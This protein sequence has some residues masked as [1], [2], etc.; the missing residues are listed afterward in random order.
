M[1]ELTS[2]ESS[3][4]TRTA[5]MSATSSSVL[6]ETQSHG[7]ETEFEDQGAYLCPTGLKKRR[8]VGG[9]GIKTIPA[10]NAD[11][12]RVFSLE[13]RIKTEFHSSLATE[14]VS[15]SITCHFNNTYVSML[16]ECEV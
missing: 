1:S 5:S 10:S 2:S 13:R 4:T 12:E 3:C 7:S 11:S 16:R 8:G 15:S 9:S 14:T 6:D